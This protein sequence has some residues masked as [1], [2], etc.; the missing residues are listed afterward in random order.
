M[1]SSFAVASL[2]ASLLVLFLV[3]NPWLS[4]LPSVGDFTNGKAAAALIQH[5]SDGETEWCISDCQGPLCCRTPILK[6]PA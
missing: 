2:A 3:T 1:R 6:P 4:E 5:H